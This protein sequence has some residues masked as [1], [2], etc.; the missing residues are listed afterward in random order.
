MCYLI[1]VNHDGSIT[2]VAS[3]TRSAMQKL[4]KR[5]FIESLV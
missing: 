3:G 2:Y 4:N 1:T 5:S